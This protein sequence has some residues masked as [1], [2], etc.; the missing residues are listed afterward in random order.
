MQLSAQQAPISPFLKTISVEIDRASWK[1]RYVFPSEFMQIKVR[2][3]I[4]FASALLWTG[5]AALVQSVPRWWSAIRWAQTKYA[6]SLDDTPD[7]RLHRGMADLEKHH[8]SV[9]S[10]EWGVGVALEW[11]T[12]IFGYDAICHG[13]TAVRQLR[14]MELLKDYPKKRKKIGPQKCPD[15]VA[16]TSDQ[17]LHIIECKGTTQGRSIIKGAFKTA[18]EQKYSIKFKNDAKFVSQRL[19]VG[20]A[21]ANNPSAKGTTLY[22]EDPD[23]LSQLSAGAYFVNDD[24]EP[25]EI[26]RAVLACVLIERS[27][28]AGAFDVLRAASS[29]RPMED[30][31][32]AGESMTSKAL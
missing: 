30:I 11:L 6:Y 16:V 10:D 8:K 27:A 17:R 24:A 26:E 9:L 13:E 20:L 3:Q 19:S 28:L 12:N 18:R 31:P 25:E 32:T 21:I 4:D 23:E 29:D 22:V 5:V 15:F 14:R 1:G 7:L 2:P